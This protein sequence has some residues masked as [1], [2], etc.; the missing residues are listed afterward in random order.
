MMK[1]TDQLRVAAVALF[2]FSVIN[3]ASV[4][5]LIDRMSDDGRVVNHAGI[6]RG[7]TQRLIKL[8]LMGQPHDELIAQLDKIIN[9]LIQGNEALG[10]P[11]ANDQEFLTHMQTVS[12]AWQKLKKSIQAL[13]QDSSLREQILQESETYFQLTNAAVFAAED[14]SKGK[15]NHLKITS[16]LLFALNLLVLIGIGWL[17]RNIQLRLKKSVSVIA[18]SSTEIASVVAQQE[19][20]ASHQASAVTQTTH[21]MEQLK[22]F[23]Q[24]SVQHATTA[25]TSAS[26]VRNL[27]LEGTKAMQP[28]LEGMASLQAKV[29]SMQAQ[30][31]HLSEQTSQISHI[32]GLVSDLANQTNMLA[33]NAAVEAVHAKEQGKG[34]TVI[35]NEIRQLAD[36]SKGSAEKINALVID[37][38]QAIH[39]TVLVT[40]EGTKTVQQGV[41]TTQ[42]MIEAFQ[43]VTDAIDQIFTSSKQISLNAK[44][45]ATTIQQVV[46]AMNSLNL[47]AKESAA[48]MGQAKIGMQQLQEVALGL[49]AMV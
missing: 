4:Y 23:S 32:S 24:H 25:A 12:N 21:S 36:Q 27:A 7:A 40:Q 42:A 2:T 38:Q 39:S 26:Q 29:K 22:S 41:Q 20:V 9:G 14:F 11:T 1:T 46:D 49:D 16:L 10:L 13:R 44:E 48:G 15:V 33:L 37:I 17:T 6:I 45:Q 31:Q 8:E 47:G 19:S 30:I 5:Y 18:S 34:F 3:V 35:A 43:A 28:T